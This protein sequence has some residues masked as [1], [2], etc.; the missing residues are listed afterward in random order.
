MFSEKPYLMTSTTKVNAVKNF[1]LR[2]D[3]DWEKLLLE[4]LHLHLREDS[5]LRE[6]PKG[7]L[8]NI[9]H[10]TE[11][12]TCS[13]YQEQKVENICGC[14]HKEEDFHSLYKEYYLRKFG[15]F[16]L[17]SVVPCNRNC[18]FP[19]HST[20]WCIYSGKVWKEVQNEDG[21]CQGTLF[22]FLNKHISWELYRKPY[23]LYLPLQ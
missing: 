15:L 16:L 3:K 9:R 18:W 10:V 11:F 7:I 12:W 13:H 20:E 6:E 19:K 8:T 14:H 5:L 23:K 2:S 1:N 4:N 21:I 17:S 22:F